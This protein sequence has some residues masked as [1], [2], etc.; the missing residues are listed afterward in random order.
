MI[1]VVFHFEDIQANI[2]SGI[3]EAT[4]E[5]II[6][7]ARMFG[8]THAFMIDVTRFQIG[9]YYQHADA[10][11]EFMR[12]KSMEQFVD[13]CEC[14][15]IVVL[16][17]AASLDKEDM[18]YSNLLNYEHPK[19]AIYVVGADS[20]ATNIIAKTRDVADFVTVPVA[21][22]WAEAAITACLYDRLSKN[23]QKE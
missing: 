10:G 7:N 12:L 3:V 13:W 1:G 9:Q 14:A 5:R 6:Y 22:L 20:R 19:D 16:E 8:A 18:E 4:P 11:I 15:R 23:A 17:N 2:S 21:D